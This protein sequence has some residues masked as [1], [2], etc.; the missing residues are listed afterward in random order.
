MGFVHTKIMVWIDQWNETMGRCS[1]LNKPLE[2]SN[3]IFLHSR[4]LV[5]PYLPEICH[6]SS[7]LGERSYNRH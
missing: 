1:L 3:F 7:Y 2:R 6:F 4:S 5:V